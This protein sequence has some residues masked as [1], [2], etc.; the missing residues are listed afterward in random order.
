MYLKYFQS[1]LPSS[2]ENEDSITISNPYLN[3]PPASPIQFSTT[4]PTGEHVKRPI[5]YKGK[6]YMHLT[7]SPN[8]IMV[9]YTY[10]MLHQILQKCPVLLQR[11]PG[12]HIPQ[13]VP[14][15]IIWWEISAQLL[16]WMKL[17]MALARTFDTTKCRREKSIDQVGHIIFKDLA[18]T[19]RKCERWVIF[20]CYRYYVL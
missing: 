19:L 6:F 14:S 13:N 3:V 9:S 10:P 2:I 11:Y 16:T 20:R 12:K 15:I 5:W 4:P 8:I 1:I 18:L 7:I 17:S